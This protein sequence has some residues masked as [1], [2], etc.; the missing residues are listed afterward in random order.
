MLSRRI[1]RIK[2]IKALYAHLKSG[3]DNM[4]VSERNMIASIDKAY[5]LY[6]QIL[7]LPAKVADFAE[8]RIELAKQKQ[9]PTREDLNPNTK[10]IDNAVIRIIANSDSVND[11]VSARKLN[12]NRSPELIRSLYNSMI[13]SQYY[14]EYMTSDEH[15]L[16]ED[17]KFMAEF[18]KS[19]QDSEML[20]S[21][22]EE[23]SILWVDDLFYVI[24]AIDR[25]LSN[26]R[27]SHVELKVSPK[28]KNSDDLDF[29]KTLFEKTLIDYTENQKFIEK[30]T[31]NWD[32][33]RIVFMDNLIMGT[34]LAELINF[35]EIPVKVTLDEYIDISKYYSTPGSSIFIN[36][37]LDKAAIALKNEDRIQ[38]VGRGL[39]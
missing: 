29:V 27:P 22:I 25:T 17:I 21:V 33:E 19:I 14:K 37:V 28:F 34:A 38:K 20:D 39:I 10:F 16:K 35:S 12:W 30:F 18:F 31:S 24:T 11:Y 6:F 3:S 9:L 23:M 13:E 2:A 32:V 36:G 26:I 15:S 8:Q 1:L 4:M 5:D 7:I